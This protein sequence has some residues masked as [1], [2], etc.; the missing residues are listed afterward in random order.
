MYRSIYRLINTFN[1][2]SSIRYYLY[3]KSYLSL[4]LLRC[5]SF[6][7]LRYISFTTYYLKPLTFILYCRR[8]YYFAP[9]RSNNIDLFTR[10]IYLRPYS[11]FLKNKKRCYYKARLYI[12]YNS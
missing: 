10:V 8:Y 2:A 7:Y 4:Y 11:L 3:L 6:Y 1:V 12:Y 5:S 9:S